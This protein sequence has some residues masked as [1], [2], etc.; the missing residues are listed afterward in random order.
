[1]TAALLLPAL[2]SAAPA[3]ADGAAAGRVPVLALP[4]YVPDGLRVSMEV[5]A[6]L[7][8]AE[9]VAAAL[10]GVDAEA[11]GRGHLRVA[12]VTPRGT[13]VVPAAVWDRVRPHAGV[14]VVIRAVPAGGGLRS[15][16]Q[17]VVAVAAAV[18]APYLAPF[19]APLVG[20]QAALGIAGLAITTVG[21]LL[22]NALVPP[23]GANREAEKP[24][25]AIA[26]WRNPFRPDGVMP[27]V[28]GKIRVA[29]PFGAPNYTEIV[30]NK[31]YVR[32]AFLLG[33]GELVISEPRIGD[34]PLDK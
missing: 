8:I 14:R 9:I 7:T 21:G 11:G 22:I 15:I 2:V 5:P 27:A 3:S 4:H 17:V 25:Y 26:G 6:G 12:L 31:Q 29:P 32:A 20:A 19:L 18:F 33:H 34:T 23:P 13:A 16:L 30:G 1:M 28:L 10:P 24:N